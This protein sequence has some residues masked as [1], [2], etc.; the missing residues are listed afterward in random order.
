MGVD[1][2]DPA[3]GFPVAQV[4]I[5]GYSDIL[6]YHPASSPVLFTGWTRDL[7]LGYIKGVADALEPCNVAELFPDW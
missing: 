5:P 1:L 2:S 7:P 6:P 4:I 3:I